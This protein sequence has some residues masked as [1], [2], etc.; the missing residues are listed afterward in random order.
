MLKWS[1]M[2]DMLRGAGI[3]VMVS[4]LAIAAG[5][6]L[7][8]LLALGSSR[9]RGGSSARYGNDTGFYDVPA[10]R[11]LEGVAPVCAGA[12]QHRLALR[13]VDAAGGAVRGTAHVPAA[14]RPRG[15]ADG[16]RQRPLHPFLLLTYLVYYALPSLGLS[17]DKWTA[18]LITLV[19]YNTPTWQKSCGQRGCICRRNRPRRA[20]PLD[21]RASDHPPASSGRRGTCGR[22]P[23]DPAH[24]GLGVPVHH[25]ASRADLRG[26]LRAVLLFRPVRVLPRRDPAVL[27][28]VRRR[29]VSGATR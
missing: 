19:I 5:V 26:E 25:H 10:G 3:T 23:V 21:T 11:H 1:T 9:A 13:R 22:E 29:R 18:A 24:Q 2:L 16:R 15:G 7:G 17:L 14:L 12:R 27:G 4:C 28:S 20:G 8:L 6:P